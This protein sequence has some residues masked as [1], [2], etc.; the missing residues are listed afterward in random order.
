MFSECFQSTVAKTRNGSALLVCLVLTA[1][2]GG[3]G[4]DPAPAPVTVNPTLSISDASVTEGDTGVAT[5]SFTVTA[6][7]TVPA[8]GNVADASVDYATTAGSASEGTDFTAASGTLQ[9]PGGT[10]QVTIAVD[11]VGDAQTEGNET[12]S[13]TLSA[14]TNATISQ[15]TATGT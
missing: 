2:G 9:I 3:G 5:L 13:V 12:F 1:C 10:T 6:S 14:P 11:I 7:A 8:G 4:G 15:A